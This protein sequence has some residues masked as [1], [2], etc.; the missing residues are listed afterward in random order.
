MTAGQLQVTASVT[1]RTEAAQFLS[2]LLSLSSELSDQVQ[3]LLL[4]V[5]RSLWA[6]EW[7][8]DRLRSPKYAP[9]TGHTAN[10]CDSS[11]HGIS[12]DRQLHR[13][14]QNGHAL[15]RVRR[16]RPPDRHQTHRQLDRVPDM[17]A[18]HAP[19]LAGHLVRL[20]PVRCDRSDFTATAAWALHRYPEPVPRHYGTVN[21][22][23]WM[24]VELS[25]EQQFE[26][27]KQARTLLTSKDAGP[28]AAALLKQAC[29]QQQLLQ[30]AVNEIAR[31]ECE[32]M[33]R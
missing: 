14:P 5:Q 17:A 11:S 33:G 9:P 27:E 21:F 1:V 23:Q 18:V 15:I 26:I 10:R 2:D 31:L 20:L 29:Y 19:P 22:G 7:R 8:T 3:D 6:A 24:A 25:P 32:L 13:Q 28:M 30:Q 4:H 16:A 12:A